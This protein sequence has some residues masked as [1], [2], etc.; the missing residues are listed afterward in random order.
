MSSLHFLLIVFL[1]L[2]AVA[3]A[4]IFASLTIRRRRGVPPLNSPAPQR[5]PQQPESIEQ[6]LLR[7]V[8]ELEKQGVIYRQIISIGCVGLFVVPVL[9]FQ[10]GGCVG[11]NSTINELRV[12]RII[13]APPTD[14]NTYSES[15]NIVFEQSRGCVRVSEQLIPKFDPVTN[16][17]IP[18]TATNGER[19]PVLEIKPTGVQVIR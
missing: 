15:G 10:Y 6:Q 2:T 8:T 16:K 12:N 18:K 17:P 19:P 3:I 11:L 7:R 1:P 14:T 13:F 5:A 4:M 9:L